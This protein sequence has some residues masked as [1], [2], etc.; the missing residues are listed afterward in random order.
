MTRRTYGG[1]CP[2]VVEIVPNKEGNCR[3]L[4]IWHWEKKLGQSITNP[5][6]VTTS[7]VSRSLYPTSRLS[8]QV[9]TP[10]P[11]RPRYYILEGS[12]HYRNGKEVESR[13]RWNWISR[14]YR[15]KSNFS[16]QKEITNSFIKDVFD[17]ITRDGVNGVDS[18]SLLS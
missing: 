13:S 14:D 11:K 3:N 4:I 17:E 15:V 16:P 6:R 5:F 9:T 7:V 2:L 18:L 1:L 12:L 10:I 8:H